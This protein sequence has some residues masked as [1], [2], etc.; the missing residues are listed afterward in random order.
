MCRDR[1]TG[2]CVFSEGVLGEGVL[3][4]GCLVRRCSVRGCSVRGCSVR[5]CSEGVLN[6]FSEGVLVMVHTVRIFTVAWC[7]RISITPFTS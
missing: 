6:V 4:E 2:Y 3:G 1:I 5:G 7:C